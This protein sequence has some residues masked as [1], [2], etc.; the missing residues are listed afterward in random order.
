MDQLSVDRHV[1]QS[2]LHHAIVSQ[3][4]DCCG[5]LAG[6]EAAITLSEPL[7]QIGPGS[8][9]REYADRNEISQIIESW[10]ESGHELSG[11]YFSCYSLQTRD[12]ATQ[13]LYDIPKQ[14]LQL[15]QSKPLSNS[16]LIEIAITMDIKGRLEARAFRRIETGLTEI[17]LIMQE[18]VQRN[19]AAEPDL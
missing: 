18:E 1:I 13:P 17:S 11:I 2:I 16:R 8:K 12:G 7:T 9:E 19:P 4:S 5:I 6:M 10:T 3:P 15:L 14:L